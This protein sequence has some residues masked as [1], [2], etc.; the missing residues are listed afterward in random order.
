MESQR[1]SPISEPPTNIPGTSGEL[2]FVPEKSV[3]QQFLWLFEVA[4]H[5]EN[6]W[7]PYV[8]S[9]SLSHSTPYETVMMQVVMA[10]AMVMVMV[11]AIQVQI[12]REPSH[13]AIERFHLGGPCFESVK[14]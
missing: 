14:L 12:L 13:T 10:I 2:N 5:D 6:D 8:Q 9:W 1:F 7:L 4:V 3:L 11:S